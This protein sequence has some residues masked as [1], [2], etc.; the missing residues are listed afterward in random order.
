MKTSI[1]ESENTQSETGGFVDRALVIQITET[2]EQNQAPQ[3]PAVFG[4]QNLEAL[5]KQVADEVHAEVPDVE[6]EEGRKRIR[7]MAAK[8]ASSKTAIDKPIR[9]HLK[10]LKAIP[11]VLELNARESVQRFDELKESIMAPLNG[12]QASQ[13]SIV[14]RLNEI[15]SQCASNQLSSLELDSMTLE[16]AAVDLE[17]FWPELKKKAKVAHEAA[18]VAVTDTLARVKREEEQAAELEKLRQQAAQREQ[19]D[20]DRKI[21]EAA[22][23]KAREDE[24]QR[25]AFEREQ[26]DRR[27]FEAKQREESQRMAA[28]QAVKNAE[29][30]EQRREQQEMQAKIDAEQAAIAAENRAREQADQAATNERLRIEAENAEHERLAKVRQENKELRARIHKAALTA[31]IIEGVDEAE[32]R[33]FILALIGS[34][35]PNVQINY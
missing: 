4:A 9:E 29:L 19:E 20:R 33:K 24:R 28:E 17:L 30:A 12:A 2:P 13:D 11:K 21:A 22:A 8:V 7:S 5:F 35:I 23:E 1:L 25:A 31:A 26:A 34:K 18:S 6:T 16:V 3:L 27:A 10:A 15:L 14:D 32:A